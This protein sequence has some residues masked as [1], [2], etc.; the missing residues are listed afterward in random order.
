[1]PTFVKEGN[2]ISF[3]AAANLTSG[4]IAASNLIKGI[5]VRDVLN[6]ERAELQIEGV[7]AV[8]SAV[9]AIGTQVTL[10][11]T[12]QDAV[13]TAANA[14]SDGIVVGVQSTGVALVKLERGRGPDAD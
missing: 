11:V 2:S 3:T 6:G 5:V 10:R 8:A 1:M 9:T 7:F 4:A 12:E 13:A 14:V